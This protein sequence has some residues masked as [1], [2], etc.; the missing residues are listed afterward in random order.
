MPY[1][2]FSADAAAARQAKRD[3]ATPRAFRASAFKP[4]AFDSGEPSTRA[5]DAACER[6]ARSVADAD[7]MRAA[8]ARFCERDGMPSARGFNGHTYDRPTKCNYSNAGR[9]VT[10]V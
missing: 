10:Y 8:Y 4:R 5:T 7:A 2:S 9:D 1:A 3:S 6:V